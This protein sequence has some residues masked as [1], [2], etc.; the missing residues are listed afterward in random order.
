MKTY[1]VNCKKN[2]AN[3]KLAK[4]ANACIKMCYLWQ[5]N[6]RSVKVKKRVNY[7]GQL[8]MLTPLIGEILS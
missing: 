2:T 1:C 6:I 3:I 4:I 7:G 8:R 5:K